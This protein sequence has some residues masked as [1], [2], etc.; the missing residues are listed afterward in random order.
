MLRLKDNGLPRILIT[1]F[2][3]FLLVVSFCLEDEEPRRF[4]GAVVKGPGDLT[5]QADSFVPSPAEE[6]A[7][8]TKTGTTQFTPL[9]SGFHRIFIL[10]G[11]HR[12]DS[13]F[14]QASLGIP[15]NIKYIDVKNTIL[16]KLRI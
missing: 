11:T 3:T 14:Y 10:C 5:G 2:T 7:L 16:L 1:V 8:V 12:V 4:A 9:R 13:V 15:S 6:P